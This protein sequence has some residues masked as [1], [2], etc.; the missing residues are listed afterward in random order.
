[1]LVVSDAVKSA[2]NNDSCLKTLRVIFPELNLT[3]ENEQ[4]IGESFKLKESVLEG[5]SLEFIGCISSYMSVQIFGLD[6]NVKNKKVEVYVIDNITNTELPLFKGI[7]DSAVKK[8]YEGVK[9]IEAYDVLYHLGEIDVTDWYNEHS[10]TTVQQLLVELA[11]LSGFEVDKGITMPNG[12]IDA[13]CGLYNNV[14]QLSALLLLK[15]ICQINGGFGRINRNGKFDMLFLTDEL[16]IKRIPST[17]L[18][19]FHDYNLYPNQPGTVEPKH[20]PDFTFPYYESVEFEEFNVKAIDKVVIRDYE[21]EEGV[22]YGTG[23]NK[24]IIQGNLFA[25]GQTKLALQNIAG[26]IFKRTNGNSF[27][28][29]KSKNY[30][31]PWVECGDNVFYKDLEGEEEIRR[32]FFVFS[33][34]LSGIQ[35]MKDAYTTKGKE[36]QSEFVTDLGSKLKNLTDQ[37]QAKKDK[38]KNELEELKKRVARLEALLGSSRTVTGLPTDRPV[39]ETLDTGVVVR[40]TISGIAES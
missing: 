40:E 37:V 38:E 1:M 30:G 20:K 22:Y 3:F 12:M 13:Y 19:P 26:Q 31:L 11:E 33:R 32:S 35:F 24:Y 23:D 5:D 9:T 29:F 36:N 2:Y 15:Q 8:G 4:I 6:A 39:A 7:V 21:D 10:Q 28:P 18:F 27:T 16:A 14:S 25:F 17:I 34:T